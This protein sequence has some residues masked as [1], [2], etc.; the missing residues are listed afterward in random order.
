MPPDV[1]IVIPVLNA[2]RDL[3][4]LLAAVFAQRPHPP[5]E[6]ILVDSQSTDRTAAIGRSF[7]DVRIVPIEHFSHGRARNLGARAAGGEFVVLLTQDALPQDDRWLATLL[8]PFDDPQVAAV[9]SRQIPRADAP[10]TERFFLHHRFPPG[11]AIRRVARGG[12]SLTLEDVFFSNV[13]AAIRRALLLHFPFDETL[14]MSEDQQF[15]RDLLNAGYTVVYQ[16]ESVVL[17]SHR[18]TL[19][20]AFQRYFDSVYSLTL[21]FPRHGMGTSAGMGARYV[22]RELAFMVRHHPLHLPYYFLYTCAKT[23][24]ALA[25][26]AA[27]R[28]PRAVLKKISLHSYHWEHDAPDSTP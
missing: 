23:A 16:P 20:T 18:Y 9:Y 22:M 8:A 17:H 25:A 12:A 5:R 11:P 2:E 4:A 27:E 19:K 14:I 15:S 21:V 1:S 3:R 6:V 10:P 13:S 28:L 26:H 7:A 24:G